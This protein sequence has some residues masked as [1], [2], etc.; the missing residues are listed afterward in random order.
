M[1]KGDQGEALCHGDS[2]PPRPAWH[3]C[4]IPD[5]R[6]HSSD[7]G[8]LHSFSVPAGDWGSPARNQYLNLITGRVFPYCSIE[9]CCLM[10]SG[11]GTL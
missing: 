8:P 2:T 9:V 3:V 11:I 1:D 5:G 6:V 4:L 10:K 7:W